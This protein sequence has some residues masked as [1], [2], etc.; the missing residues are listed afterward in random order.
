MASTNETALEQTFSELAYSRLR[1][2][3]QGMLDYLVGFQLLKQQDDGERAVGIFGCEVDDDYYYMP[4][5][6]L[7][8]EI[9]GLESIYSVNADLFVPLVDGWIDTIIHR[10]QPTLGKSNGQSKRDFGSKVPEY[11]RLRQVPS[12]AQSIN[13]KIATELTTAMMGDRQTAAQPPLPELLAETRMAGHFKRALDQSST[14][15]KAFQDFGYDII[16]LVDVDLS[17]TAAEKKKVVIVSQITDQD[18]PSLTDEQKQTVLEGGAV[19]LD[20]RP[21]IEKA[22][23]YDAKGP[24]ALENPT[25]GGLYDVI[26]SDGTISQAFL[27]STGDQRNS[28]LVIRDDDKHYGVVKGP[29]I[30]VLRKYSD[31]ESRAWLEDNGRLPSGLRAKQV[32]AFISDDGEGTPLY[33]LND[34]TTGLDDITTFRVHPHGY[35]SIGPCGGRNEARVPHNAFMDI[36][37]PGNWCSSRTRDAGCVVSTVLVTES[38]RPCP[39]FNDK[40]LVINDRHFWAVDVNSFTVKKDPDAGERSPVDADED[41]YKLDNVVLQPEDFGT[42]ATVCASLEKVASDLRVWRFG[43]EVMAKTASADYSFRTEAQALKTLMCELGLGEEDARA[44]YKQ[45]NINAKVYKIA[46]FLEF[47]DVNDESEGGF[48]GSGFTEQTPYQTS[49]ETGESPDNREAYAYEGLDADSGQDASALQTAETAAQ[50]GR[51]EVFDAAALA[52][53]IKAHKPEQL[54]ERFM[55]TVQS[56]MDRLGRMLFLVYWHYDD[57]EERYGEDEL[58][59]LL[60]S[61]STVFEQLGDVVLSIKEKSLS[62]NPDFF[63]LPEK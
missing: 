56:G 47:P 31:A 28:Y 8:G 27:S 21:E 22:K 39:V 57:F 38:G 46:A 7:H 12:G 14:L 10:R 53:L 60:D 23:A 45:A 58:Q 62:G 5:F 48:M 43:S 54:V 34:K 61:L 1:D 36:T 49:V 55:P 44:I 50:L 52:A 25:G 17:K 19:V 18:A 9:R 29:E 35:P 11:N 42:P 2:R 16:D 63:G 26:W 41:N 4:V 15:R 3:A 30:F 13:L 51:K 37:G 32:V 24:I 33:C 40:Q 59:E 20:T 6:F